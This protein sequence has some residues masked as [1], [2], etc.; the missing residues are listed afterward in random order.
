MNVDVY[1][2]R[3]IVYVIILVD[4]PGVTSLVSYLFEDTA[5]IIMYRDC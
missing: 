1:S 2:F 5:N 4:D 3:E